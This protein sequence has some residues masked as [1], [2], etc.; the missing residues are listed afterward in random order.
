M[1]KITALQAQAAKGSPSNESTVRDQNNQLKAAVLAVVTAAHAVL[2]VVEKERPT[3]SKDKQNIL[4]DSDSGLAEF[5]KVVAALEKKQD[6]MLDIAKS[7]T[8]SRQRRIDTE[9][10]ILNKR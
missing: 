5:Q 3:L 7:T 6:A 1:D 10:E 4:F 8:E 2:D 9:L